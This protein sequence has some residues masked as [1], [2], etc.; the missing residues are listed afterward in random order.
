MLVSTAV[1][2]NLSRPPS[3]SSPATAACANRSFTCFQ[4]SGWIWFRSLQKAVKSIMGPL[5]I[6]T[7]RRRKLL[8]SMR[9]MICRSEHPSMI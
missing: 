2:S 7:K 9:T 8:S 4:V 6:R 5:K 3:I 1:V